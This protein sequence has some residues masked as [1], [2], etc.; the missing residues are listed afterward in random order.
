MIRLICRY[1]QIKLENR[2]CDRLAG[3]VRGWLIRL[4]ADWNQFFCEVALGY[5]LMNRLWYFQISIKPGVR[6]PR[7]SRDIIETSIKKNNNKQLYSETFIYFYIWF[8]YGA[9][10][11]V[12]V[13]EKVMRYNLMTGNYIIISCQIVAILAILKLHLSILEH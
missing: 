5:E 6:H 12:K 10:T 1:S 13:F 4:K 11:Y 2:V 3:F 7:V 8:I 9:R